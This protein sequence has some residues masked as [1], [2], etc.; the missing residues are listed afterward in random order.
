VNWYLFWSYT[1]AV[2]CIDLGIFQGTASRNRELVVFVIDVS[3]ITNQSFFTVAIAVAI[4]KALS[5]LLIL[6]SNASCI[7]VFSNTTF[8]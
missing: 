4:T 1:D 6:I 8:S 7:V 5:N 3:V 2:G